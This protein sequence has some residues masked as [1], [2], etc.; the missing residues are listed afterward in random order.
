MS[1]Q[2]EALEYEHKSKTPDWFW[3]LWIISGGIMAVSI[4]SGSILFAILIFVIS[5]TLSLQA[6]QKPKVINFE[7]NEKGVIV[8]Q[9]KYPY[10]NLKS[11]CI[12]KKEDFPKIILNSKST[13]IP[14][15]ILP[16]E[17]IEAEKVEEFLLNHLK[18]EEHDEP[19]IHKLTKYF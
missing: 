10:E 19:V 8:D 18:K 5:F 9:S 4:I 12:H 7:V 2:W 3:S 1:I 17:N 15:I 16:L 11:F 13:L 6:V 14:Y